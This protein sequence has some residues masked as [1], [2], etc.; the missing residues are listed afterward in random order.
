MI[1]VVTGIVQTMVEVLDIPVEWYSEQDSKSFVL[2]KK[3]AT[4]TQMVDAMYSRFNLPKDK[5]K[6]IK[7]AVADALA[8]YCVAYSQSPT[9]KMM[10]KW[11]R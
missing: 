6:Y 9:L 10:S 3:A 4:K 11:K 8:I 7:E 1:G 5:P 2:G